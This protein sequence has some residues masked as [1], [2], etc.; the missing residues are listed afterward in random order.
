[1]AAVTAN[2]ITNHKGASVLIHGRAAAEH[3]YAGTLAYYI[4]ASG[5]V[6]GDDAGGA[7]QFAGIV[8]EEVD[9]SG[10]SAGDLDVE[11]WTE[12]V[13]YLTS[14]GLTQAIVGDAVYGIDN[15]T[16]QASATTASRVGT[17]VEFVSATE[18]GVK[19]ETNLTV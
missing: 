19:L 3:L 18:I 1:M 16:V 17:A 5:Y 2:Q 7:N 15:Y 6:T 9:N 14:S 8:R 13:F 11:L 4:A 12:G 10:G